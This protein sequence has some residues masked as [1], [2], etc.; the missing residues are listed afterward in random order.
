MR[1]LSRHTLILLAYGLT[2]GAPAAR[3]GDLPADGRGV[4]PDRAVEAASGPAG[5][6][7]EGSVEPP[8]YVMFDL[9]TL[10][11]WSS[12]ALAI[13][14]L[15]QVCGSADTAEGLRR[16]YLWTDGDMTELGVLEPWSQ[17]EAWDLNN[18]GQA[19]GIATH[20]GYIASGFLWEDGQM[21]DIGHLTGDHGDT[22]AFGINDAGQIVGYSGVDAEVPTWHAFLWDNG[23]MTDLGTLG[24]RRSIAWDINESTEIVGSSYLATPAEEAFLWEP[25]LSPG[26]G[27]MLALGTLG[28]THS[29]AF[30]TNESGHVVGKALRGTGIFSAFLWDGGE[31]IDIGAL[32]GFIGSD[33]AA[34][35]D[36]GQ[37]VGNPPYLY[38]PQ[39]GIWELY[40]LLPR[41]NGWR[42]LGV[43]DVNNH[44]QIVGVGTTEGCR[45]AFLMTP[46]GTCIGVANTGGEAA[47]NDHDV[48]TRDGCEHDVCVHSPNVYGDVNQDD[49]VNIFDVV[50]VLNA[51][52]GDFSDCFYEEGDLHPCGGNGVVNLF[53][54]FAA[55]DAAVTG[56]DPCCGGSP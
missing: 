34:I 32:G 51:L 1:I 31:M 5:M 44:T 21:S 22:H 41:G 3:A 49:S 50:C 17:S 24:G 23:V 48:C 36:S 11:G 55:L 10:G 40:D 8:E 26:D 6:A 37:I 46:L 52:A 30:G 54:V 53:D 18:H 16:A 4:G 2:G 13:N 20:T 45:H 25:S 38:D 7:S 14:D 9:G 15:G 43:Y 28:G 27:E 35:N 29:E 39:L 47:C 56:A 19:V 42:E 12:N 33:A